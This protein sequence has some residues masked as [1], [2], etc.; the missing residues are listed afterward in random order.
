[1][2]KLEK[3]TEADISDAQE[4]LEQGRQALAQAHDAFVRGDG[5]WS[6]YKD[7]EAVVEYAEAS[8]LRLAHA[9]REYEQG[10]RREE[11]AKL[12]SEID[13]FSLSSG[14]EFSK[15]LDQAESALVAFATAFQDRNQKV[16]DWK[17]RM[18]ALNVLPLGPSRLVPPQS[19]A[20]LG[21]A[22]NYGDADVQAGNRKFKRVY[23]AGFLTS[24][25]VSLGIERHAPEYFFDT[26]GGA[27]VTDIALVRSAVAAIDH[28]SPAIPDD[29]VFF[30]GAGGGVIVTDKAHAFS[31]EIQKRDHI[32]QITR[33]EALNG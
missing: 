8:I 24:L 6:A 16:D 32:E 20:G 26:H 22:D 28:E 31:A 33:Q 14:D 17:A 13:A 21:W 15:L 12:R 7:Q 11:L 5:E 3:V 18:K 1:M 23:S 27:N 9:K 19:E 2:A 10:I 29:A 4:A 25:L 30:R